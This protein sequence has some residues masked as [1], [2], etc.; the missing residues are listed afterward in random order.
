MTSAIDP[1]NPT[2]VAPTTASVR[3]NFAAAKAEIEALQAAD[4]IQAQ[5][6]DDLGSRVNTTDISG[7]MLTP[8]CLG[9]V[10][11]ATTA[12][13]AG[14]LRFYTFLAPFTG[15][16]QSYM[17]NITT[18]GAGNARMGLYA[19]SESFPGL[20]GAQL[21]DAGEF[22]QNSLGVVARSCSIPVTKGQRLFLVHHSV[23]AATYTSLT[24]LQM[25]VPYPPAIGSFTSG[26]NMGSFTTAYAALPASLDGYAWTLALAACPLI[27]I[28]V[29]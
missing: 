20:P 23:I 10:T 14:A 26:R 19:E 11:A 15:D 25:P 4:V 2:A 13:A 8:Q 21:D 24:A 3:A 7:Q 27:G 29:A 1:A 5:R 17:L 9:G 16:L 18:I 28:T 22:S 12:V 6:T